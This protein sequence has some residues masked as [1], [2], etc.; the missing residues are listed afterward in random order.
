MGKSPHFEHPNGSPVGNIRAK[1]PDRQSGKAGAF[2][3]GRSG[4]KGGVEGDLCA[5]KQNS[6]NN[7]NQVR[8]GRNDIFMVDSA[9]VESAKF[10]REKIDVPRV[11]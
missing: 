3:Y 11:R 5:R 2:S 10:L 7:L 1:N 9:T 8:E 4:N 6:A